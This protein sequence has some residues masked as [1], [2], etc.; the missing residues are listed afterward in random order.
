MQIKLSE[1][2]KQNYCVLLGQNLRR[3]RAIIGCTQEDL[4]RISGISKERISRIENGAIIMRW[5]QFVNF[6]MIF[7]LNASTKEYMLAAKIIT[8]RLLQDLQL[9]DA[10]VPPDV[11][12]P[13]SDSLLREFETDFRIL[14]SLSLKPND[15]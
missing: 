4:A 7:N 13:V 10:Q 5:A 15:K 14:N 12:V 8:P 1:S 3:L 6:L 9:K 11:I 2:D